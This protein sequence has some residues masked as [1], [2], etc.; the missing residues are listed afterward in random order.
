MGAWQLPTLNTEPTGNGTAARRTNTSLTDLQG[1]KCIMRGGQEA[2]R[3]GS[4][5][6][7]GVGRY[8]SICQCGM[9][10][11]SMKPR[12]GFI[13]GA[14]FW[15]RTM[16]TFQ[17]LLSFGLQPCSCPSDSQKCLYKLSQEAL[18]R[19]SGAGTGRHLPFP[20]LTLCRTLLSG[21]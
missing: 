14:L 13:V 12:T 18:L 10:Y 3:P 20:G 4:K 16:L 5:V 6:R 8:K 21:L 11:S 7:R 15:G 1:K 17:C 9:F 2:L 19:T